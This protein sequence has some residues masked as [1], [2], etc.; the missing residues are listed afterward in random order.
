MKTVKDLLSKLNGEYTPKF[1]NS[2]EIE[3]FLKENENKVIIVLRLDENK[4]SY[5]NFDRDFSAFL[6]KLPNSPLKT[7]VGMLINKNLVF[8]GTAK[9][10]DG[11]TYSRALISK[12]EKLAGIVLNSYAL[13]ISLKDGTTPSIDECIYSTYYGMIRSAVIIHKEEIKKDRELQRLVSEFLFGLIMRVMGRSMSVDAHQKQFLQLIVTYLFFKQFCEEKHA[14]II[15]I[16]SKYYSDVFNKED[17][18]K[19]SQYIEKLDSFSS[20]KDLPKIVQIFNMSELNSSQL[21]MNLIR[22]VGSQGFH[23]L[24]G[25][26]DQLIA[27]IVLAKY[28]TEIVSKGFSANRELQTK[29]ENKIDKYIKKIKFEDEF[30]SFVEKTSKGEKK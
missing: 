8:F 28:P 2:S 17:L 22:S 30:N 10:V 9:N 15:K 20:I 29:I 16:V 23:T 25:T 18:E 12:N 27:S 26:L 21:T 1:F 6:N 13:D 7:A 4:N 24:L 3:T 11:T 5:E 14:K 19:Y